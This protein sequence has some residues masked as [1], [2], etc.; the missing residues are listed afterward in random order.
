MV[1]VDDSD[2]VTKC[3]LSPNE[4][5]QL[6]RTAG[7]DGWE[8]EVA[9]QL[10]GRCGL[11]A[12]EVSYPGDSNLRYSD[13]GDI[14]LFEVQG[15]NTKGGTKKTRDAW[16]PDDVAD[17]IHKYSRERGLDLSDSWVDA[18]TPSVRRWVKEAAHTVAEQTGNPRWRSVSSHDL[19]RSWAT[20]HLVERQVDV[21][22]MM[23][24]GGWSDYSAIEPY[25][26]EPTEARIGEAMRT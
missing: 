15:K 22:T 21:R 10:M 18:S 8:R 13:D 1:R 24:I 25:L 4:L 20:Y 9:I 14:W 17:D 12:S 5:D 23:S 7:E 2:D 19:R 6:E 3:W 16:M 26:A 11:R